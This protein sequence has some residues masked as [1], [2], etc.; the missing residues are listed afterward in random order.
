MITEKLGLAPR[1]RIGR[2]GSL[3]I[4]ADG[5][6]LFSFNQAGRM[7]QDDEILRLLQATS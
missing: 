1:V 3:D 6:L 7:P 2:P 5:K 4:F